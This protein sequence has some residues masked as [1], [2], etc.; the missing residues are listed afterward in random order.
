MIITKLSRNVKRFCRYKSEQ[1]LGV[2][3]IYAAKLIVVR[4]QYFCSV[5]NVVLTRK[6]GE[7]VCF[8]DAKISKNQKFIGFVNS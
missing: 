5:Y 1:M 4:I 8:V 2:D 6:I 3:G 7:C